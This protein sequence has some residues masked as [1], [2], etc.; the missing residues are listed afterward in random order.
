MS[1]IVLYVMAKGLDNVSRSTAKPR[2]Y[3]YA[4]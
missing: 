2:E 1:L 4:E 3:L